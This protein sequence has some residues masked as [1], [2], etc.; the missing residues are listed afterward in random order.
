MHKYVDAPKD[1]GSFL[2]QSVKYLF[3]IGFMKGLQHFKMCQLLL[4]ESNYGIMLPT[5]F[6]VAPEYSMQPFLSRFFDL[7]A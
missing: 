5:A 4:N 3:K 7:V 1:P 2:M 6:E